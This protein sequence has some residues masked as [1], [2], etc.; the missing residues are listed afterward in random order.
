MAGPSSFPVLPR[1]KGIY[2]TAPVRRTVHWALWQL[3]DERWNLVVCIPSAA[4][5][6]RPMVAHAGFTHGVTVLSLPAVDHEPAAKRQLT[7]SATSFGTAQD[8]RPP[9]LPLTA[10]RARWSDRF[11]TLVGL[12]AGKLLQVRHKVT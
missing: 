10:R 9:R 6:R 4:D 12:L 2:G 7:R 11:A 8:S 5:A 3:V 1:T